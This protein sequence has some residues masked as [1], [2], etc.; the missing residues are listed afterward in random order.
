MR[1]F[2]DITQII[3]IYRVKA[4]NIKKMEVRRMKKTSIAVGIFML[5]AW[6]IA[7]GSAVAADAETT[8]GKKQRIFKKHMIS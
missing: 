1:F 3:L 7:S 5:L 6:G 2:H 4:G 8:D